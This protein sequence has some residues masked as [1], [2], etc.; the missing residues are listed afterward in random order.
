MDKET[1]EEAIELRRYLNEEFDHARYLAKQKKL[2]PE[3]KAYLSKRM[4]ILDKK[5]ANLD[6]II[7]TRIDMVI[8]LCL[9]AAKKLNEK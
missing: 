5:M 9:P 2:K 3:V 6:T 1:I 4:D 7:Q 8:D